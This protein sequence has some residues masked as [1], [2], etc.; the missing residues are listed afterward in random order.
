MLHIVHL[1]ERRFPNGSARNV[2]ALALLSASA[3]AI[4]VGLLL[5]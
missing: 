3:L 4:G 1:L 2:A 5:Q